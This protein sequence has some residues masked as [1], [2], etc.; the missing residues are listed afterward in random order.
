MQKVV[1]KSPKQKEKFVYKNL[2][3]RWTGAEK[4]DLSILT[5][6]RVMDAKSFDELTESF[7]D[8]TTPTLGTVYASVYSN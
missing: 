5:G 3:M 6:V 2:S 8:H 1:G 7:R 4:K